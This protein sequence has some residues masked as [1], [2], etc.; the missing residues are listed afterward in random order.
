MAAESSARAA[1]EIRSLTHLL[2]IIDAPDQL[3]GLRRLAE[4]RNSSAHVQKRHFLIIAKMPFK[5]N[6]INR[7]TYAV[8]HRFDIKARFATKIQPKFVLDSPCPLNYIDV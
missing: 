2:P 6:E 1:G 4:Q 5:I 8:M 7:K 3:P